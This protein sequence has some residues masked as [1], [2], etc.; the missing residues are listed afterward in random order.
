MVV[1][2]LEWEKSQGRRIWKAI[3]QFHHCLQND[4]YWTQMASLL[5][6]PIENIHP[7]NKKKNKDVWG[8]TTLEK[9]ESLTS[10]ECRANSWKPFL[11]GI[12]R[13]SG[14]DTIQKF[15][16]FFSQVLVKSDS[17]VTLVNLKIESWSS[18]LCYLKGRSWNLLMRAWYLNGFSWT[19][20]GLCK[21]CLKWDAKHGEKDSPKAKK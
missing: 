3:W 11:S 1:S 19:K 4:K 7:S 8:K 20:A 15:C 10:E 13:K 18:C 5:P 6:R 9:N 16:D 17:K 21:T 2:S 12:A 14:V